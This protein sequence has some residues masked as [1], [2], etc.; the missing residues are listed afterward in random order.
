MYEAKKWVDEIV[1]A[2]SGETIQEGTPLSAGNFN[3]MEH[4]ITDANLATMLLLI[5]MNNKTA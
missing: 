2:E 1:D 5:A 3:N 4:G